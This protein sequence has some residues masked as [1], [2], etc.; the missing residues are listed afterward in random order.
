MQLYPYLTFSGNCQEAMKFYKKCLGGKL[1]LQTIGKSPM[2]NKFPGAMKKYVLHAAL[3]TKNFIMMASDMTPEPHLNK[4][5]ANSLLINCNSEKEIHTV[6][7]N[8]SAGGLVNH[9]L[10]INNN[11]ALFGDFKDKFGN[12]WILNF[13]RK[14]L[15]KK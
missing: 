9:S 7:T 13:N 11:G 5:N 6:F 10:K 4:G 14:I 12:N 2:E 8:L 1:T 3:E 15:I